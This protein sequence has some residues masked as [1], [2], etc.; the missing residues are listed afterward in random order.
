MESTLP[1]PPVSKARVWTGRIISA[2][3]VLFLIFDDVLKFT[4]PAPVIE[5]FGHLGL[6]I[7]L[8]VPLGVI[9]LAC[10]VLY[11]IPRTSFLGAI[12]LTGYFGGAVITHLRVGDP[13]FSHALFPST[14]AFWPGWP[15]SSATTASPR[16]SLATASAQ[17]NSVCSEIRTRSQAFLSKMSRPAVP[18]TK[19]PSASLPSTRRPV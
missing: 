15:S 8:S 3:L 17:R 13:L 6:P 11:A 7:S 10:T 1:A 2:L 18:S 14:S 19:T 12:L 16:S 5:A 9:L 4:R